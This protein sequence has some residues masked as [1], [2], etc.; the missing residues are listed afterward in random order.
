MV[1]A[2]HQPSNCPPPGGARSLSSGPTPRG[3]SAA[4]VPAA[5]T[6]WASAPE[7]SGQVRGGRR[8]QRLRANLFHLHPGDA[9]GLEQGA[10]RGRGSG[11][12]LEQGGYSWE[13]GVLLEATSPGGAAGSRQRLSIWPWRDQARVPAGR[14]LP[15]ASAPCEYLHA[16]PLGR[17]AVPWVPLL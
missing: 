6:A 5:G 14:S 3:S 11:A 12:G 15:H 8:A 10:D 7:S 4:A 9:P 16:Q 1:P 2:P 17:R 13:T